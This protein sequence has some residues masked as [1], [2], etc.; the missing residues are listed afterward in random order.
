[1]KYYYNH[2]HFKT[3]F[4]GAREKERQFLLETYLEITSLVKSYWFLRKRPVIGAKS[5]DI[6]HHL[7]NSM[8]KLSV[9]EAH[10]KIF[11][12]ISNYEK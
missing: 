1:M 12:F 11:I 4:N 7:E 8:P 9:K 5:K 10:Q 2:C 6:Y 3:C